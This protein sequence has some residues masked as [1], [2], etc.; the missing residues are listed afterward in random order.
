MNK[1]LLQEGKQGRADSSSSMV[2]MNSEHWSGALCPVPMDR[3]GSPLDHSLVLSK[4]N[5]RVGIAGREKW[6]GREQQ[7]GLGR[8]HQ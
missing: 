8:A 3:S 5:L 1:R 4:R 2:R 6:G 7:A